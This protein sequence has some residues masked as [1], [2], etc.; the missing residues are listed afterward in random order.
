MRA[1]EFWFEL[2]SAY[3][4]TAAEEIEAKDARSRW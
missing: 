4:Y 2:A 3:S 1:L